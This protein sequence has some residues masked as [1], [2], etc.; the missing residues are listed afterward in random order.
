M[1]LRG[2]LTTYPQSRGL[3]AKYCIVQMREYKG[4]ITNDHADSQNETQSCVM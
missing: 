3:S 1:G 4:I 2:L